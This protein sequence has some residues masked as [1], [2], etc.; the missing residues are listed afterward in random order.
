M[1]RE[2][3]LSKISK[4]DFDKAYFV[5]WV[6]ND[7]G[8]RD[9][10]V[11]EMLTNKKIMVYYH[12]YD[13]ISEASEKAP[14]LF[15]K[16]WL[17][18]EALL[19]HANSYHRDIGLT[20][21]ANLAALDNQAIDK[22]IEDYMALLQDEKFMTAECCLKNLEKIIL[23]QPKYGQPLMERVLEM[24]TVSR[25]TEKQQALFNGKIIEVIDHVYH[26]LDNRTIMNEF[27]LKHVDSIS[28]KARKTAKG[29]IKKYNV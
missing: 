17:K 3:L 19:H 5:D 20:M 24:T 26:L 4:K 6:L 11:E 9:I 13:V 1:I 28:P 2:E 18:Y 7:D 8:I 21:I 15:Y 29:F 14:E 16:D 22:I 27:V 10:L 23:S 12:C 25:Y